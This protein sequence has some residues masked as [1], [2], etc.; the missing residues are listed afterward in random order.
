MKI[1]TNFAESNGGYS[2]FHNT[3]SRFADDDCYLFWMIDTYGDGWN[4]GSFNLYDLDGN[5]IL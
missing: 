5:Q 4:G 3:N 2:D 1:L